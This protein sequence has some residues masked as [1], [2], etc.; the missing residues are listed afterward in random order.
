[1]LQLNNNDEDKVGKGGPMDFG[2]G[3]WPGPVDNKQT[4]TKVAPILKFAPLVALDILSNFIFCYK[5][6]WQL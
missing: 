6:L 2:D 4:T 3:L 5:M 1:V